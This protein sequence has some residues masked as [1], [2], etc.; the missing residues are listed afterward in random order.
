MPRVRFEVGPG[1][2]DLAVEWLTNSRALVRAVSTRRDVV[3]VPVSDA[4]LDLIDAYLSTW[5]AACERDGR[6]FHWEAE[7]DVG[8]VQV[9]AD[10]WT[11]LAALTDEDC[12]A[13]DWTWAPPRTAPMYEAL[14]AGVVAALRE[15]P[16][17]EAHG[18]R[19]AARPP[20]TRD[21]G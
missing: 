11:A 14:V 20:G 3:T 6:S 4:V 21:D 2:A 5:L 18:D 15:D 1:P 8:D 10:H 12:A 17:T 19:F 13:L 16:T 9:L 7:V